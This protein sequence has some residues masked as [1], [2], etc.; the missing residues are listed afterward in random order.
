MKEKIL[1]IVTQPGDLT[2]DNNKHCSGGAAG[3]LYLHFLL[4]IPQG[5]NIQ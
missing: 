1:S 3:F 5:N 2:W 4:Y